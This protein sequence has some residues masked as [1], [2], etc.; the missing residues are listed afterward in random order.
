MPPYKAIL[1][2][3]RKPVHLMSR[4][5][6]EKELKNKEVIYALFTKEVTQAAAIPPEVQLLLH[7]YQDVFPEDLPKG[8]PPIRGIEHQID[9]DPGVALPNKPAYKTNP[10]ET[11]ELQRQVEELLQRGYVRGSLSPCVVPTL[12]VP[13]KDRT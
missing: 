13:K 5:V 1:P 10:I 11:K 6:G 4:K 7:Q 12:L 9:L 3:I 2:P 8:L